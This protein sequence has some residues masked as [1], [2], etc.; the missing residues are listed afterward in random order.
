M[1]QSELK[2][3]V[4]KVIDNHQVGTLSTVREGKPYSRFMTF[5]NDDLT[6]YTATSEK[7]HKVNDIKKNDDVHI[8]LGYEGQGWG[9]T[10]LEI[11]AKANI[12]DSK[13]IKEKVWNEE[14][15]KWFEGPEDPRLIIL[16]LKP[17]AIRL[18]NEGEDTPQTL[19]L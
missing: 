15:S 13:E 1:N 3:Q 5:F 19:E 18:M 12:G 17:T 11:E 10:Y 14:L 8:L 7:T 16:E 6:L 9:D 2:E 4:L